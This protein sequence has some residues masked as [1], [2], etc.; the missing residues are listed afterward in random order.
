MGAPGLADEGDE[1]GAEF[2]HRRRENRGAE[3]A[4]GRVWG[5]G[6]DF[7]SRIGEFWCKL[8]AFVQFT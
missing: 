5:G 6:V 3:S 1:L 2:E 8:G 7:G 4:R